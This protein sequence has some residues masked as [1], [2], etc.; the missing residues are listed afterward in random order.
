MPVLRRVV[1]KFSSSQARAL[2]FAT[3]SSTRADIWS[4]SHIRTQPLRHLCLGVLARKALLLLIATTA[5]LW[6]TNCAYEYS[7][8]DRIENNDSSV[9]SARASA[10]MALNVSVFRPTPFLP[11]LRYYSKRRLTPRSE[12]DDTASSELSMDLSRGP[13]IPYPAPQMHDSN[14]HN[15]FVR[16]FVLHMR[17]ACSYVAAPYPFFPFFLHRYS[18][19]PLR[20]I[21]APVQATLSD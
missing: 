8:T 20:A 17:A 18:A 10:T 11:E 4:K 1:V 6:S 2:T 15:S 9:R 5:L 14:L 7:V 19:F 12:R 16:S 13:T 21:F 3:S